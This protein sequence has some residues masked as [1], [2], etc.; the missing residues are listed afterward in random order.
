MTSA[1]SNGHWHLVTNFVLEW[2]YQAKALID[3]LDEDGLPRDW[4]C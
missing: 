3:R 4:S 1:I 2:R